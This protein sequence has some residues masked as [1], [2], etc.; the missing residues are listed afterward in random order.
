M[1]TVFDVAE[2]ILDR[3]GSMTA[4]KL[5]KLVY[6]SQAWS[7]VWDELPLFNEPI[8]AWANGPVCPPLYA[9]HAGK[10]RV[11]RGFTS[12]GDMGQLTADEKDTVD[13]VLRHYGGFR[14][15]QL[16][17]LTHR[18]RPWLAARKGL[19]PGERSSKVISHQSMY[20]FYDS[21]VPQD[22]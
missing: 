9:A 3:H 14:A 2:Y 20:E 10:L 18:E 17:E 12:R 15:H 8:Q 11:I 5:Q 13:A 16:S 1:A 7:L 6:Y 21:L 19:K 22:L 4:M